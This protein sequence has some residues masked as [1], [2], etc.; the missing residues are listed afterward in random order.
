MNPL[1][2]TA[3]TAAGL[4]GFALITPLAATASAHAIIRLEGVSAVASATSAMTLLIQHGCL[5]SEPTVQVQAFVGKPWRSVKP[6]KVD[7]WT[8]SVKK[9]AKGGWQITWINQGEPIP[10]GKETLFPI[11]VSWPKTPGTYGMS[12]W[13][14]CANGSTYYWNEKSTA[15]TAT[16]NSPPLTPR[17]EVL[18]VEKQASSASTTS[19]PS[20][21]MPA[22]AHKH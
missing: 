21:T 1:T 10:F 17:P 8:S 20:S 3:I 2:R 9:Q 18:V 14:L 4:S 13:Q 12:V 22:Q 19:T 11:T 6:Q 16:V 15:A 5:P 7:G